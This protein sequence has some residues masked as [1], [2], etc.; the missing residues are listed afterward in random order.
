L[1][2]RG[3]QLTLA[4]MVDPLKIVWSR[5]LPEGAAPSMTGT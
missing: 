5:P 3:H 4:K 1:R 2:W